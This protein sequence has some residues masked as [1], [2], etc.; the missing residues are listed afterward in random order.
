M[1]LGDLLRGPGDLR[2][3]RGDLRSSPGECVLGCLV[4]DRLGER[5]LGDERLFA[6]DFRLGG[7]EL[8]R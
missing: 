7:G 6:G 8:L 4:G 1:G 3:S 5:R 2:F